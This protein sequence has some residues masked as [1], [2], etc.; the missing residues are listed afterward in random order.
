MFPT[1]NKEYY[2]NQYHHSV[3]H[4]QELRLRK[5]TQSTARQRQGRQ[6][7]GEMGYIISL[8]PCPL[9]SGIPP[10]N[11]TWLGQSGKAP[12]LVQ[13]WF[14]ATNHHPKKD[15]SCFL[16]HVGPKHSRYT[17]SYLYLCCE[18]KSKVG[19]QRGLAG[20]GRRVRK[21]AG[22]LNVCIILHENATLKLLTPPRFQ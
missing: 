6:V 11:A 9:L 18:S 20:S 12:F 5:R 2:W 14:V 16:S 8:C 3:G 1:G 17:K 19:K 4:H 21:K 10:E 15:T 22:V 13:S 7:Q